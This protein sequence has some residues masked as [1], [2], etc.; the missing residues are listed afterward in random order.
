M[1][2]RPRGYTITGPHVDRNGYEAPQVAMSAAIN[3]AQREPRDT[4]LYVRD[5]K[6]ESVGYVYHDEY[7][8][9]HVHSRVEK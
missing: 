7:G 3:F 8:V 9:V 6:G 2:R 5:E 1:A 4:T